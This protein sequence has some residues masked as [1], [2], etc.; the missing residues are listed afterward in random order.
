MSVLIFAIAMPNDRFDQ[1]TVKK[2]FVGKVG[3]KTSNNFLN[4]E[5]IKTK[6]ASTMRSFPN[7]FKQTELFF[8]AV[9][10]FLIA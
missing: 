2:T 10:V 3:R 1:P 4:W 8:S 6:K 5:S 7:I 9:H